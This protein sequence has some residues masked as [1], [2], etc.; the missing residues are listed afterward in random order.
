MACW[1]A[2]GKREQALGRRATPTRRSPWTVEAAMR[3]AP[4]A[5]SLVLTFFF[6]WRRKQ[7]SVRVWRR[8]GAA[9]GGLSGGT[10]LQR[11]GKRGVSR[12]VRPSL[13]AWRGLGMEVRSTDTGWRGGSIS[14]TRWAC[15]RRSTAGAQHRGHNANDGRRTLVEVMM[16]FAGFRWGVENLGTTKGEAQ[17]CVGSRGHIHLHRHER[18]TWLGDESS[19]LRNSAVLVEQT[20]CR[21]WRGRSAR[22]G[23]D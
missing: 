4:G 8:G 20:S 6:G 13:G 3:G 21:L 15:F 12:L 5:V 17:V 18:G 1:L 7:Q 23:G 22:A 16:I 19:Q 10:K 9:S 2:K 14:G 11:W